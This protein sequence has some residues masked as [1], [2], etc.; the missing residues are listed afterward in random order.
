MKL[1]KY[2]SVLM[3]LAAPAF[4]NDIDKLKLTPYATS[5]IKDGVLEQS[6]ANHTL[7]QFNSFATNKAKYYVHCLGLDNVLGAGIYTYKIYKD[8]S[9][10]VPYKNQRLSISFAYPNDDI[11]TY[12]LTWSIQFK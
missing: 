10:S 6:G 3:L 1:K 5:H 7:A 11:K 4:A 9:V 8:K 2:C 12:Q